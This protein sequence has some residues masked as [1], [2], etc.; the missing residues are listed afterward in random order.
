V[1][2]RVESIGDATLYLGDCRD[3]LPTLGKVDAV[4]TDPPYGIKMANGFD[5]FG[6]FG[7]FGAPIKRRQYEG[8]WD[9]ARPDGELLR[10]VIS[11]A[12]KSI[13]WGGQ[14]FADMLPASGKWFWWDKCQTM[15]TFGDG[16]LAWTNLSGVAPKKFVYSNNG[17][18]A[19]ERDRVHSTQKPVALMEWC[20]GFLPDART[21]LDP[22]MGSGTTGVACAKLD[23]K[24]IGIE[25]EPKYFD[26]ACKR[27]DDAYKQPRLFADAP[28]KQKQEALL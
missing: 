7:G 15:P 1:S 12:D 22:F 25:L 3:I 2:N 20:L 23:R 17:L 21:I 26:I 13:V 16:E 8:K 19:K 28:P 18:M 14:Y 4:V 27:I 10:A 9:D 6:G 5:G 11:A 24:F